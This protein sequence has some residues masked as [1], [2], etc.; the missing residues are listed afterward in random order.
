MKDKIQWT[1]LVRPDVLLPSVGIVDILSR[2]KKNSSLDVVYDA[3]NITYD[4]GNNCAMVT[5]SI[6]SCRSSNNSERCLRTIAAA[7]VK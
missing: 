5:I 3:P 7:F 1:V 6:C 4:K 2:S